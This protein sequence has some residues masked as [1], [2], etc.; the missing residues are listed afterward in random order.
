MTKKKKFSMKLVAFFIFYQILFISLTAP[1]LLLYG[2]FSNV[3]KT[4]VG[5]IMGTQHTYL[6]TTFLSME[7]INK[8]TNKTV[9]SKENTENNAT[10]GFDG[11]N[12]DSNLSNEVKRWDLHP[13]SGRYDGYLLE[14]N[15]LKIKVAMTQ[16]LGVR[17]EKTSELA[18]AHNA[19]AAINGG[20]FVDNNS[21]GTFGGSGANPGGFV[22]SKGIVV[23]KD[24][25]ED[26]KQSVTAFTKK[27][28]LIVGNYSINQLKKYEVTEALCFRPPSLIINGKGQI[29]DAGSEG[30]NP[31]TAIGQTKN[32]TVLLLV[33]DGRK[34]LIKSGATLKDAQ[35]ELLRHGAVT[36]TCLD[37]GFSST[38]YYDG[39]VISSPHGVNGERY[40]AT[41][42]YVEP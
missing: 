7:A 11:I 18:K 20:S 16:K 33:M 25:T 32:G 5:T 24:C 14:V 29:E 40:V 13:D 34:N 35:E 2:P 15:P 23:Y 28:H 39:K 21:K 9:V 1:F 3:K 42:L 22:I 10:Q 4:V 36:A 27:G 37:G 38:M 31:R 6:V 17:G 19:L 12:I 30:L 26:T 8:I 41:A